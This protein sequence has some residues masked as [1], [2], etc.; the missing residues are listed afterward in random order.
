MAAMS[1]NKATII[2]RVAAG[3]SLLVGGIGATIVLA[4]QGSA[5]PPVPTTLTVTN[6]DDAGIGSLR[7]AIDTTNSNPGSDTIIFAPGLVGT[8]TLTS[9]PLVIVDDLNIIGPGV[10]LL[11]VSGGGTLPNFL[12]LGYDA[13]DPENVVISGLTIA[14][15][16]SIDP[17]IPFLMGSVLAGGITAANMSLTLTNVVVR[18]NFSDLTPTEAGGLGGAGVIHI[19]SGDLDIVDSSI[20]DNR[21]SSPTPSGG[22]VNFGGNISVTNSSIT[23]N[24]SSAGGGLICAA[25]DLSSSGTILSFDGIVAISDSVISGNVAESGWGGA[26]IYGGEVTV[27]GSI[28]DANVVG[29][30]SQYV[31]GAG[32]LEL[33]GSR[34]ITIS[35][36]R[37]SGNSAPTVGGLSVT[38]ISAALDAPADF[39]AV[40]DRLTITDNIGGPLGGI[41]DNGSGLLGTV[42]GLSIRSSAVLGSST[43]SGNSGVGVDV[44]GFYSA[45]NAV[46]STPSVASSTPTSSGAFRSL[47]RSTRK[48]VASNAPLA[49]ATVSIDHTT[50]ADNTGDG[51]SSLRMNH[52]EDFVNSP[53]PT[54]PAIAIG[55]SLLAGNAG[56]DLATPATVRWSLLQ[57]WPS[58]AVAESDN[59]LVGYDPELQPLQIISPTIAVRPILFGSVAWNAGNP[60]FTPPPETD[61][62]G[63]P[64]IV[65]IIDIGAYEVQEKLVTPAFT[66]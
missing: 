25:G 32:G 31:A 66:G 4:P 22:V 63:L 53:T 26:L 17:L 33:A 49:P 2:G 8:I 34:S 24:I 48:N 56:Q 47:L 29:A 36:T 12:A 13:I 54:E 3:S 62:R 43:I 16:K 40:L 21:S 14:N 60:D 27:S 18:D 50:I 11:T 51:L 23:G 35:D 9:A 45:F 59:N 46:D 41:P 39:V 64:R 20:R 55:H 6:L 52:A 1:R 28:F 38:N 7:D 19:G 42:G 57:K 37:V 61:Q 65:N 30:G 44:S 5:L 15:G 58:V 10:D